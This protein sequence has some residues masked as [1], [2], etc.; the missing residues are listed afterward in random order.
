MFRLWPKRMTRSAI[1]RQ[2]RDLGIVAAP[3]LIL[4]LYT[5]VTLVFRPTTMLVL[6]PSAP[7]V[8]DRS[9]KAPD[10]IA[11]RLADKPDWTAMIRTARERFPEGWN[12]VTPYIRVVHQPR[13]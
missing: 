11:A 12:S 8:I 1:G 7:Q 13:H 10:P 6:G 3:L 5:G 4:A 9:L 2:H